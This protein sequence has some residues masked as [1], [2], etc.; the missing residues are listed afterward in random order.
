MS[1]IKFYT[2]KGK[3]PKISIY[4]KNIK[5][6]FRSH[7]TKFSC[8]RNAKLIEDVCQ[9]KDTLDFKMKARSKSPPL[10]HKRGVSSERVTS[11]GPLHFHTEY[12]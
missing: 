11:K 3:V 10:K 8:L 4:T 1:V 7:H 5:A 6:N 9:P 2:Q 12:T